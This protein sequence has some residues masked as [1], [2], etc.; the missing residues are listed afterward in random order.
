LERTDAAGKIISRKVV[1]NPDFERS[2]VSDYVIRRIVADKSGKSVVFEIEKRIEDEKG[3][4]FRYM[5]ET[6]VLED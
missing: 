6:F 3:T 4:S 1:G 2:G 5:V